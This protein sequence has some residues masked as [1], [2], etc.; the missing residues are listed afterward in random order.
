MWEVVYCRT[1]EV[2]LSAL[3]ARLRTDDTQQA[4][5]G[6]DCY[7][8]YTLKWPSGLKCLATCIKEAKQTIILF[9]LQFPTNTMVDQPPNVM[10]TGFLEKEKVRKITRQ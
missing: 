3:P 7:P 1:G 2:V 4:C 9:D 5:I 10:S 6:M 8:V